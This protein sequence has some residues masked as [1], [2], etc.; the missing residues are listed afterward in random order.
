MTRPQNSLQTPRFCG[1]PSFMRL[2]YTTDL[3]GADVAVTGLPFDTG[4]PYRVGC[5]FGPNALRAISVM[6]RPINVYRK[7]DVFDVLTALDYGDSPV[8]P[9][10]TARSFEAMVDHLRTIHAA[11]VVP[12]GIGGDH[13]ITFPELQAAAERHGPLSLLLFDAHPDCWGNYLGIEHHAGTWARRAVEHGFVDPANSLIVGLRGSL[14]EWADHGAAHD[15]GY[16]VITMDRM[17]EMG[18]PALVD[19]INARLAGRK[20]FLS[21]DLDILDP[22]FAPGIQTPEAGGMTSRECLAMLRG[23][24]GFELVGA[25]VVECNPSYDSGQITAMVGATVMAELIAMIA[26][27][28]R[29]V[30]EP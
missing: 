18:L 25:D 15:L 14:F 29:G 3:T 2:P 28:K 6:L 27:H 22:A 10:E 24:N 5:R 11:G 17:Y 20:T 23:L 26:D 13:A 4:S 9:G 12:L 19:H 21:F 30:A 7:I 1:A 8:V 16:E